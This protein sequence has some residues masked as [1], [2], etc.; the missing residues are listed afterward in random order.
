M[1]AVREFRTALLQPLGAPTGT[2]ACYIEV[3][4]VLD[5]NRTVYPDGLLHVS[6]GSK[7]WV[8]LVEVKTGDGVLGRE[9]VET[10]VDVARAEG[11]DAVI[12]ISNEME[13]APGKHPVEV[14]RRKLKRVSLHHLSWA[15]ILTQA[16][17]TRVFRGVSDPDQAWIL[18]ELIR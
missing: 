10:Y 1:Q 13:P 7:S 16:V 4:C 6:R 12:T 5:E 9:Q 8:A 18:G 15:Q 17:Q 2:L 11:F 3:P 14:D